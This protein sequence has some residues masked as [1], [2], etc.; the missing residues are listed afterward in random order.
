MSHHRSIL[1]IE[2][3]EADCELY[4]R[5]LE[6]GSDCNFH[7]LMAN[8]IA[9][10]ISMWRSQ[11][12]DIVLLDLS[13]PDGNGLELLKIFKKLIKKPKQDLNCLNFRGLPDIQEREDPNQFSNKSLHAYTDISSELS[14]SLPVIV[15]SGNENIRTAIEAIH[16]GAY[17]YLV[18]GDLTEQALCESVRGLLNYSHIHQQLDRAHYADRIIHNIAL[19]IRQMQD[20]HDICQLLVREVQ[21]FLQV[22]RALVY[23]FNEQMM[24]QIIAE[25]VVPAWQSSISF[26]ANC[27]CTKLSEEQEALYLSGYAM[28]NHDIQSAGLTECHRQMLEGFQVKANIAMPVA[29]SENLLHKQRKVWGLLI[30][31]QCS[32][33]RLWQDYEVEFLEK[34]ATHLAIAIQQSQ[35]YA[36]LQSINN[37][38]ELQIQE[39]TRELE[40]N[41]KK[42]SSIVVNLPDLIRLID[43]NGTY[44]DNNHFV[45]ANYDLVPY[46]I[47]IK[48]RNIKELVPLELANRAIDAIKQ[49]VKL[50][51][52]Q[53]FEQ[54]YQL[55]NL[56]HYEEVRVV[57]VDETSALVIVRDISDRRRMESSLKYSEDKFKLIADT[58]PGAIQIFVQRPDGSLYF[59]YM[60]AAFE[61]INELK[62]ADVLADAQLCLRQNHPDDVE[63]LMA[64][65]RQSLENLSLFHCE[66]RIITASGNTKWI[67]A[68]ARPKRR[69]N[70]D[71]AWYGVVSDV[72]DRRQMELALELKILREK[73]LNQFIQVIR[74][75]F[76]LHEV[77]NL[78]THAV[79]ALLNLEQAVIVKYFPDRQ[80]WEHI[81]VFRDRDNILD[82]IGFQIPDD[83]NPFAE[84]LKRFEFVIVN[85]TSKIEDAVNREI[86]AEIDGAWLLMPIIVNQVTWGSLTLRK[87]K[88]VA[89][90]EEFEVEIT[91]AIADQLAIAIQQAQLYQQLQTEL[92]E[93]KQAEIDLAKAK[94]QA[95]AA[96]QAKSDFLANMSHEIRTPM[97]G[98]LGMAQ[99]L[100]STPLREDQRSY[101]Q[102]ILDSG[103]VLLTIINDI[104]DFSKIESGKLQLEQKE[105]DFVKILNSVCQ[106]LGKTAYDR[107]IHLQCPISN[108]VP[109]ILLGDASRLRQILINLVGNAIKFTKAGVVSLS[110]DGKIE[111]YDQSAQSSSEP[112]RAYYHIQV[113]IADTGI[114]IDETRID[115]LFQPF[116]QAD[117]SISRQFGGTGLGLAIC[118]RLVELMDGT[119]WVESH[120]KIGGYPPLNW[121]E[122]HSQSYT[123]GATFYFTIKLPQALSRPN[124]GNIFTALPSTSPNLAI[125]SQIL[126]IRVLV[127]E[128]N[129]FN[130]KIVVLMLQ[131]MG[132]AVDIANNGQ[133]CL[134]CLYL[135]QETYELAYD[136]IFMDLQMPVMDGITV[137]RQI[138]DRHSSSTKPWIIAL[139]AD[140]MSED[141]QNCFDIGM[142]D[143]ISKPINFNDLVNSLHNYRLHHEANFL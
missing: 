98:V 1:I 86:A 33:T 31:H 22:D 111:Y 18:K 137:T 14:A 58:A 104:L 100:A 135:D 83:N 36:D 52:V 6:R 97:N 61:E 103:D 105:F 16:L 3:S 35:I 48:G 9:N 116:T 29:L 28:I 87:L 53:S 56:W 5:Y 71:V 134:D 94:E 126:P 133:E 124:T 118:K 65:L 63:R 59:E 128:D 121:L 11:Q 46:G 101:V 55:D 27:S 54:N 15:L 45:N 99:I 37:S 2:D 32:S 117:A 23:Q 67:Q 24:R 119:I 96:N 112:P 132:Y 89:K 43:I 62:I 85:D 17:D 64:E 70:G 80:I 79:G 120:G 26:P 41:Q 140:A 127:V 44:L 68:Y 25:E 88:P 57:K 93:R 130:Q 42:L 72:S 141:V 143:Y 19:Q 125:N 142:N 109:I 114:G 122:Q 74:S 4:R 8:T 75:S 138:R 60:S 20:I 69:E 73:M 34:V 51:E 91:Q 81:A 113:A 90:W 92:A 47:D 76:D 82:S 129:I 7:F 39:R 77:F 131:K 66:W 115:T 10:G 139:T 50:G 78:A 108:N 107:G 21:Q 13:L 102:V 123:N 49:A 84:Q 40:L 38:L 106:L 136:V 12:P 110:F 30:L 95:E